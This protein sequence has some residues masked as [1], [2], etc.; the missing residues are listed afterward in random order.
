MSLNHFPVC[1]K[2][3]QHCKSTIFQFKKRKWGKNYT[4]NYAWISTYAMDI[5]H[6]K[7]WTTN[8]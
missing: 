4:K 2:L 7:N 5:I 1:Q 6:R 3:T 8:G